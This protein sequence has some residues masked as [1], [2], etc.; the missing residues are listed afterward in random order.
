M[1]PEYENWLNFAADDL[2]MAQL[3]LNE[4][5]APEY[6][7]GD[8][9]IMSPNKQLEDGLSVVAKLKWETKVTF[10]KLILKNNAIVLKAINPEYPTV[11]LEGSDLDK[12][13]IFG[14]AVERRRKVFTTEPA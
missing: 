1:K 4:L 2:K 12:V 13:K 14:V 3:A 11:T 9:I 6:K 8:I 7:S 5:M 10:R